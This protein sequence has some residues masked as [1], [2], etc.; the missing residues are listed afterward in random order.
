MA[1]PAKPAAPTKE[2]APAEG[3]APKSNKLLFIIIGVLVLVIVGGA[4]WWFLMGSKG[5][6][7]EEKPK[8]EAPKDPKFIPLEAFTVN[9]QREEADQFLQATMSLKVFDLELEGKIKAMLPEIRSKVNLLLSSKKPSEIRSAAGMRKLSV[10]LKVAI[11]N[12][13]GIHASATAPAAHGAAPA[14]AAAPAV[15]DEHGNPIP[16]PAAVDE[17]G[18]PIPAPAAVDEHGNPIPATEGQA[19][20]NVEAVAADVPVHAP[21]APAAAAEGHGA[22]SSGVEDVLFTSFI[23]Q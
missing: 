2:A 4:A 14:E 16:A 13:L 19:A 20:P 21:P 5:D 10:D 11:N 8:V 6:H 7:A 15:V 1:K 12:V 9:L 3:A 22:P 17:H 23:I 18:N